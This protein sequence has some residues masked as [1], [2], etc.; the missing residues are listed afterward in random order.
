[1]ISSVGQADRRRWPILVAV[2]ALT[3]LAFLLRVY[4]LDDA[5]L[6]GDE[7]FD[8]LYAAQPVAEILYQD[9]FHQIYPP[10]YHTGLHYWLLIAGWGEFALRWITGVIPGTLVVPLTYALGR[11]LFEP[12]A[13]GR[14][15]RSLTIG[16]LAALLAVINPYLIWWSQDAHFYAL[17]AMF[18]AAITLLAI[19]LWD[20]Q[21]SWRVWWIYVLVTPLGFYTHYYTYFIWGAVNLVG[22]W[23]TLTRRWSHQLVIR[24][25]LA[26]VVALALYVPWLVASFGMVSVYREPWIEHVGFLEILWRDL[27]AYSLHLV[28]QE[29]WAT[30]FAL[31][32]GAIFLVGCVPWR[33]RPGRRMDW[34]T[35][36]LVI[37]LVLIFAPLIVLYLA[38]LQRPLYDEKLTIFIL[39]L[40]L[41]GLARG[42][43][44]IGHRTR[45]IVGGLIFLLLAGPM[46][47]SNYVYF[48]DA[49]Y[50]KSPAWREMMHYVHQK[51]QPGDVLI[52][53]FPESAPLYYNRDILPIHLVPGS[54]GYSAEEIEAEL[55]PAIA[56]HSRV[57]L[58]PLVMPWWDARGDVIN[59]LD[60]HA[61][62]LDQR[63]FRGVHVSLYL[64][65]L[66]W[67]ESMVPQPAE[68]AGGIRLR[69]FRLP[70]G[71][72][73]DDKVAVSPG[74]RL[75]LSLYW[76][77][78]AP[79]DTPYT[80]FTHLV[81]PDGQLYGQWDNPPVR[82]TFPTTD[83][84]P[85]E[86]VV[87]QY[88]IPVS[89]NAPPG[90]YR[91]LIGLYD[92]NTGMR[93]PLL[94]E[95]GEPAGDHV[96]LSQAIH[97]NGRDDDS[98]D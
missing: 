43:V 69:G 37:L 85:G 52:F 23:Y 65:P 62:R 38:S 91:L 84:K 56:G 82:G 11:R 73:Q 60:R 92:P 13:P 14:S 88:E 7:A 71:G 34:E 33:W 25:W 74:D 63:F 17:L 42:V 2:A 72:D 83:W 41:A 54:A 94:A 15:N 61:D 18:A 79:T 57:W 89:L 10:L 75:S 9:R 98:L 44:V 50:A 51:A 70:T 90:D 8:V 1:M 47:L 31:L 93:S 49:T 21:G 30:P 35:Q 87:D 64:T 81:G 28:G 96:M 45:P 12:P 4:L 97:V 6:R 27:V 77:A 86:S 22:L 76:Q 67:T 53:N 68:F 26:Q 20:T 66:A 55:Q 48:F 58:V 39:P 32:A 46:L 59:W 16:W 80:V 5:S 36:R 3:L 78:D 19:R 40:A 29:S 24:W 95:N